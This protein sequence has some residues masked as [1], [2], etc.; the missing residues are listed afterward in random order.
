MRI[1]FILLVFCCLVF[2]GRSADVGVQLES[3]DSVDRKI[4]VTY[5]PP[6]TSVYADPSNTDTVF[7]TLDAQTAWYKRAQVIP[8][9]RV[10]AARY[11]I[12]A[13]LPDSTY[14]LRIE[15]CIPTD[16][17]PD[18]IAE[19][20]IGPKGGFPWVDSTVDEQKLRQLTATLANDPLLHNYYLW[21]DYFYPTEVDGKYI[22]PQERY[23][24]TLALAAAYPRS[25]L[26]EM[27]IN[28]VN[29]MKITDTATVLRMINAWRD[30]WDVDVLS[31]IAT[32]RLDEKGAIYDPQDALWFIERSMK[33]AREEIGFRTGENIFGSMGRIDMI[34]ASKVRA[35]DAL[36]RYAEAK[37]FGMNALRNASQQ[38]GR[39][40]IAKALQQVATKAG[41][42]T[43][44]QEIASLE[45]P[46]IKDFTFTTLDGNKGS[47]KEHRGKVVVMD[48]WFA[49]C[50]GCAAE[51]KALNDLAMRYANRTDVV[52]LSVSLNDAT[53]LRHYL[54][55]KP[56]A[57][58]TIPDGQA[59]CDL[60]GVTAFPTHV[61]LDKDGNT[62]LWETGGS[63]LAVEN[64]E[65]SMITTLGR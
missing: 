24:H 33:S 21:N 16:R 41:D 2:T 5:T 61:I 40:R 18:G 38:Y 12:E 63:T 55:K 17:V 19:Y 59:I 22:V 20:K 46:V 51:H 4:R 42:S 13:E 39:E 9:K 53:T 14:H 48:F 29:P 1:P 37:E 52:F 60:N 47:I 44:L 31:S 57:F 15:I 36:G 30:S 8:M 54:S 6:S 26:G 35:L 50:A 11:V 65:I 58:Q 32:R 62:V 25:C 56:L 34:A 64:L 45:K 7:C 10:D 3:L 23:D 49:G 43:L 27:W 28:R